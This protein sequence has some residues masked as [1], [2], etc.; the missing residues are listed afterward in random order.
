M[1]G[2]RREH[3]DPWEQGR[4]ALE[5]GMLYAVVWVFYQLIYLAESM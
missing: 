1:R 2:L 5:K 4:I 3:T